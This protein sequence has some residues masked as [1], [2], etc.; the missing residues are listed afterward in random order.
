MIDVEADAENRKGGKRRVM[1]LQC[2]PHYLCVCLC[3]LQLGNDEEAEAA[4]PSTAVGTG[5]A[6][7]GETVVCSSDGSED[8]D[9][10]EDLMHS[11]GFV[12]EGTRCLQVAASR[13]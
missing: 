8:G 1:I 11:M 9:G 5:F 7:A 2:N 4:V 13:S 12:E 3:L 6:S 10:R